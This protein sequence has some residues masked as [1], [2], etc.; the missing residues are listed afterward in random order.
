MM[1]KDVA[2]KHNMTKKAVEKLEMSLK[3]ASERFGVA[4][5]LFTN[6]LSVLDFVEKYSN[7]VEAVH[8]GDND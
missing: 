1:L 2:K 8:F 7:D 5:V 3:S 6:G 4:A